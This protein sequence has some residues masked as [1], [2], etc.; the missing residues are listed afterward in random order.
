MS[1]D[2]ETSIKIFTLRH[3]NAKEKEFSFS[4]ILMTSPNGK[5]LQDNR[6]LK[7]MFVKNIY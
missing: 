5:A 3:R 4:K 6:M 7:T 1:L 2:Y